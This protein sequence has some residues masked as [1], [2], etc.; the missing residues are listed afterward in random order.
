M[1]GRASERSH[2]INLGQ[3]DYVMW[4][5]HEK[6]VCKMKLLRDYETR[7]NHEI[8]VSETWIRALRREN[9]SVSERPKEMD[10]NPDHR[11]K[12]NIVSRC[13]QHLDIQK[14]LGWDLVLQ[15]TSAGSWVRFLAH[16]KRI[17]MSSRRPAKGEKPPEKVVCTPKENWNEVQE[18]SMRKSWSL[19]TIPALRLSSLNDLWQND[20]EG[21]GQDDQPACDWLVKELMYYPSTM[22]KERQRIGIAST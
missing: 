13:P 9:F 4:G 10:S 6:N 14:E 20:L 5:K 21:C 1:L 2:E 15:G 8:E 7:L 22:Y 17:E 18:T 16:P 19:R 11:E 12:T 3:L